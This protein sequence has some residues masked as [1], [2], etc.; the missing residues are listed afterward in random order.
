MK[1]TKLEEQI[2]NFNKNMRNYETIRF[3]SLTKQLET[4]YFV[5]HETIETR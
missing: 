4:L 1:G 5:F 2:Q 3:F